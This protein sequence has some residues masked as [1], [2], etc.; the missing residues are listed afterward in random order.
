MKTTT[1]NNQSKMTPVTYHKDLR[2]EENNHGHIGHE[3]ILHSMPNA[4]ENEMAAN[5]PEED[6]EEE[7]DEE[8]EMH[9]SNTNHGCRFSCSRALTALLATAGVG[10]VVGGGSVV[11]LAARGKASISSSINMQLANVQAAPEGYEVVGVGECQDV[12]GQLYPEVQFVSVLTPEACADKCKCVT[13]DENTA[14]TVQGLSYTL[15]ENKCSCYV[16]SPVSNSD[17]SPLY[18]GCTI[19]NYLGTT[20]GGDERTGEGEIES[21]SNPTGGSYTT[22]YKV[23]GGGGTSKAGKTKGSKA[24]KSN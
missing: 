7:L 20:D 4:N 16:D 3:I 18:A 1:P 24:P 8:D 12:N 15:F 2:D 19:V 10:V 13:N 11:F 9:S 23:G 22:C 6:D 5:H 14:L 21:S 17:L